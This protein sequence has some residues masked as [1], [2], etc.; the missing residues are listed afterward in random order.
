MH[1]RFGN[2]AL[3][4][5]SQQAADTPDATPVPPSGKSTVYSVLS[6]VSPSHWKLAME[7]Q[8][9]QPRELQWSVC[10]SER[11]SHWWSRPEHPC[12]VLQEVV[13]GKLAVSGWAAGVFLCHRRGQTALSVCTLCEKPAV[14]FIFFWCASPS[15]RS[16]DI[17]THVPAGPDA[18]SR[19]SSACPPSCLQC[20]AQGIWGSFPKTMGFH[21][22]QD[23]STLLRL[24]SDSQSDREILD[25]H[26]TKGCRLW[27]L[28]PITWNTDDSQPRLRCWR[29]EQDT[30]PPTALPGETSCL[31]KRSRLHDSPLT[32]G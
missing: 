16:Q 17:E 1:K 25:L 2:A 28:W 27:C 19:Q 5:S 26:C 23:F 9:G 11:G 3:R 7:T 24:K 15:H 20:K 8:R 22:F 6:L 14:W 4:C 18:R 13:W 12:S 31:G 30:H 29:L 10:H 32:V 21:S